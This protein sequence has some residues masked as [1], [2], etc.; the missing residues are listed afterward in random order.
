MDLDIESRQHDMI[1]VHLDDANVGVEE[2]WL[3]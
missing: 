1:Y 2:K 3:N